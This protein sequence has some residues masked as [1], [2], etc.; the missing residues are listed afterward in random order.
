VPFIALC[1][2]SAHSFSTCFPYRFSVVSSV[3]PV[4]INLSRVVAVSHV[5]AQHRL[6]KGTKLA[7]RYRANPV[8]AVR[9][10]TPDA[11]VPVRGMP[12]LDASMRPGPA[13]ALGG[14]ARYRPRPP[15][16]EASW[17][18][19]HALYSQHRCEQ[20]SS[21]YRAALLVRSLLLSLPRHH[22]RG[23]PQGTGLGVP[24]RLPPG[25]RADGLLR[26]G[27]CLGGLRL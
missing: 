7:G 16:G 10:R 1:S 23:T 26:L 25:I 15:R 8:R 3:L 9:V 11:A 24:G 12:G 18:S 27:G 21:P 4:A 2:S 20:V 6:G 5:M 14:Q 19:P 22:T 13:A 17:T